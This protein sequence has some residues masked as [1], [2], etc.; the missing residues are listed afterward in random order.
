M[1]CIKN[2]NAGLVTIFRFIQSNIPREDND[3]QRDE[4]G[5]S[6]TLINENLTPFEN[7]EEPEER[8]NRKNYTILTL[9]IKLYEEHTGGVYMP[10]VPGLLQIII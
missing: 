4:L 6:S 8:E 9:L 5:Y 1:K 10:A 3:T 7:A 2:K